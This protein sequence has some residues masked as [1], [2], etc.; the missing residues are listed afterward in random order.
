[1][2]L[3]NFLGAIG[4]AIKAGAVGGVGG[5]K[6]PPLTLTSELNANQSAKPLEF[7]K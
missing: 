5:F 2:G 3:L 4:F 1:M 6:M 7:P